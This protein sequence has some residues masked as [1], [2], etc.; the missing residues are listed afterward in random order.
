MTNDNNSEFMMIGS[1]RVPIRIE[2]IDIFQLD[3]YP[4]NPRINYVLSKYG[5]NL[6]QNTIEQ[7]LWTLDSTKNLAEDIRR[8]GGLIEEILVLDNQ[9]VEGNTRLCAYRHLYKTAP[10]GQK[11][12]WKKIRA[13]R[14]LEN[15]DIK[16]IFLLLGKLHIEGKTEWDPYEKA[17]YI[18]K[19]T[20]ENGMSLDEISNIVGMPASSIRTQITAYE[21]MRDNY[22]PKITKLDDKETEIKK[23]SIFLEYCRSADLQKVKKESPD[24]LTDEK[25]IKWVLEGR[26]RSAAYDVRKDLANVL[27]CKP[28]RK[29]FLNNPPEEAI[30]AAKEL[31]ALDRPETADS[32]F[33]KL[34]QMTKFLSDAPVIK[35]KGKV[36]ENPRMRS[37]VDKFHSEVQ[38]FYRTISTLKDSEQPSITPLNKRNTKRFH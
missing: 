22:L 15:I 23:F 33:A 20:D 31:V 18:Y 1:K 25:F 9:V 8:N 13:K 37:L 27:K 34:D 6:D 12:K 7:S 26:V 24:I 19:M 4:D 16:D 17:S 38:K 32:F 11:G 21:L 29:V 36:E 35:I 10:E 30:P 14:L 3:Y 2:E 5:E 28:A